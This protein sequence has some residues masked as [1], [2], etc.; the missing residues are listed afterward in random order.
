MYSSAKNYD[1]IVKGLPCEKF[2]RVVENWRITANTG[3]K[4]MTDTETKKQEWRET[5]ANIAG[6]VAS[7]AL[8]LQEVV[9]Q[10]V[11]DK[12]HKRL[13]NEVIYPVCVDLVM[14]AVM[15]K[16]DVFVTED[17]KSK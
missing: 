5:N 8:K 6:F 3:E 17:G 7:E 9:Q 16:S 12:N 15:A 1:M 4:K 10:R 2:V 13:P 11:Q 14:R